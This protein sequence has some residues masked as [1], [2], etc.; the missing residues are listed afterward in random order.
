MVRRSDGSVLEAIDAADLWKKL[1][2]SRN[3]NNN[4]N[5]NND[6]NDNS[7]SNKTN[8]NENNS[9]KNSPGGSVK[10][11]LASL[12]RSGGGDA[13]P[14]VRQPVYS[15]QTN[16]PASA[17][18][19]STSAGTA[20]Q[21][22]YSD[23]EVAAAKLLREQRAKQQRQAQTQQ[24]K[25]ELG[26]YGALQIGGGGRGGGNQPQSKIASNS[27]S[28]T[29]PSRSAAQANAAQHTVSRNGPVSL[30]ICLFFVFEFLSYFK[31][32]NKTKTKTKKKNRRRPNSA[33]YTRPPV[34]MAPT[35]PPRK[36]LSP[37]IH[38]KAPHWASQSE[39]RSSSAQKSVETSIRRESLS[40]Q[41]IRRAP[42]RS[43]Q[44]ERR[45]IQL[46]QSPK[47][48]QVLAAKK[49][50]KALKP[51]PSVPSAPPVDKSAS[52]S[53]S[54]STSTSKSASASSTSKT[55]S[56]SSDQSNLNISEV[57]F[58]FFFLFFF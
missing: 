35:K 12:V 32:Q 37:E 3:N 41:A 2:R 15:A 19:A 27:F 58:L 13:R 8:N 31:K 38:R 4:S 11:A 14:P 34:L 9:S 22:V 40:P 5:N 23:A 25:F 46:A 10:R 49:D 50:A 33:M 52:A 54:T 55:S 39:R 20:R 21:P 44:S 51:L 24:A 29:V 36:D 43:S 48:E 6:S 18:P 28:P 7:D 47:L 16:V 26:S 53:T 17:A 57:C 56:V 42:E 30:Y 45:P 1:E